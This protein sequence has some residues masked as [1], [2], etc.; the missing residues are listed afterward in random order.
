MGR[1]DLLPKF[2]RSFEEGTLN[3]TLRKRRHLSFRMA[4]QI[5]LRTE[6]LAKI[7]R[8][9]WR[10]TKKTQINYEE[11][12]TITLS[13]VLRVMDVA[14]K[15][16]T[17]E[18]PH[19]SFKK[20]IS[21][22]IGKAGPGNQFWKQSIHGLLAHR[23]YDQLFKI[24]KS[25]PRPAPSANNYPS[26]DVRNLLTIKAREMQFVSVFE[27]ANI[28]VREPMGTTFEEANIAIREPFH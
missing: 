26:S 6:T 14:L 4:D 25:V 28:V 23:L 9:E 5:Q 22:V 20:E 13:L 27:Q 19:C 18:R 24:Y 8:H 12:D 1:G 15:F 10:F 11:Q 7:K 3:K 21:R 17:K 2:E 16:K